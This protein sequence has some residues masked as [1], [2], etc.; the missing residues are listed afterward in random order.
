[1]SKKRVQGIMFFVGFFVAQQLFTKIVIETDRLILR[2]WCIDKDFEVAKRLCQDPEILKTFLKPLSD[3]QV[4]QFLKQERRD[5]KVN[6]FG[7]YAC[8]LK[9]TGQ[10]VGMVGLLHSEWIPTLPWITLGYRML[11]EHQRHGYTQEALKAVIQHGFE[12]CGLYEI[13]CYIDYR[14]EVSLKFL[15]KVGK[16]LGVKEKKHYLVNNYG[17][18]LFVVSY[19]DWHK[20]QQKRHGYNVATLQ[21]AIRR[22]FTKRYFFSKL[23]YNIDF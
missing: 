6:G 18:R 2:S 15:E 1:M 10:V 3:T 22:N 4:K 21:D 14:N 9:E 17:Y 23:S 11:P 5:I 16:P 8:V 12:Q 20:K 7:R 13:G 19:A